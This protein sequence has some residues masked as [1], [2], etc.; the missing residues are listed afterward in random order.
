MYV[1]V[2]ARVAQSI[3]LLARALTFPTE[4]LDA[5]ADEVLVYLAQTADLVQ[6][7]DGSVP[8]AGTLHAHSDSD[9]AVG[10]STTGF[11]LF[12]AGVAIC[13]SSKRQSPASRSPPPRR[14]SS[15]HR[16]ALAR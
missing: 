5:R 7:V 8:G 15:R 13:Y 14:R 11:A 3:A 12:L 4:A 16:L 1:S 6:R 2:F 10:H 9:W